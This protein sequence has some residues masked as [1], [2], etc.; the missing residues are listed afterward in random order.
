VRTFICLFY[1]Y[2]YCYFASH[3]LFLSSLV[4]AILLVSLKQGGIRVLT[5]TK[6]NLPHFGPDLTNTFTDTSLNLA[7]LILEKVI[8]GERLALDESSSLRVV[9][10]KHCAELAKAIVTTQIVND[11]ITRLTSL[12]RFKSIS[13]TP[14]KPFGL[15]RSDSLHL[16]QGATHEK[17]LANRVV[18]Q[19]LQAIEQKGLALADDL[20]SSML[21]LDHATVQEVLSG[22]ETTRAELSYERLQALSVQE[23]TSILIHYLRPLS[24]ALFPATFEQR[25][26]QTAAMENPREMKVKVREAAFNLPSSGAVI[27]RLVLEHTD[28]VLKISQ[29]STVEEHLSA[30]FAP[31]MFSG[32]ADSEEGADLFKVVVD[33]TQDIYEAP[34]PRLSISTSSTSLFSLAE[35]PQADSSPRKRKSM[36]PGEIVKLVFEEQENR[37]GTPT[38][39]QSPKK[40][41]SDEPATPAVVVTPAE[42]TSDPRKRLE[43]ELNRLRDSNSKDKDTK[44]R[45]VALRRQLQELATQVN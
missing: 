42:T 17:P 22:F 12:R 4:V 13:S 44:L 16:G 20:Y 11:K 31:I 40:R 3:Q 2:Y 21:P 26:E 39:T 35:S 41:R 27:L 36:M 6:D 1:Y 43:D 10:D 38:S 32:R 9:H 18:V 19:F 30:A 8:E 24:A 33:L 14:L 45:I 28:K 5:R 7:D 23:M 15:T 29:D 25:I 37:S 34:K